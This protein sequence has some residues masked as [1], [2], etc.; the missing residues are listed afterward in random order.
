[1]RGDGRPAVVIGRIAFIASQLPYILVRVVP[2]DIQ[3][4]VIAGEFEIPVIRSQPAVLDADDVDTAFAN[5]QSPRC[6]LPPIAGITVDPDRQWF[7]FL[8]R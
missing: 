5:G 2:D 3:S 8:E 7:I 1:M 6:L 4:P